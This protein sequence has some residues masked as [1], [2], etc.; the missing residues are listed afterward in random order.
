MP[1]SDYNSATA[2][3]IRAYF[4][5][6]RPRRRTVP[7]RRTRASTTI[8]RAYR[9]YRSRPTR[10]F[11]RKV[12]SAVLSRDPT[13]YRLFSLRPTGVSQSPFVFNVSDLK[14]NDFNSNLKYCRTSPK[15]KVMNLHCQLTFDVQD[16]PWNRIS[17]AFVRH[18]RSDPIVNADIQGAIAGALT[19]TDDKPFLPSSNNT[20]DNTY[21]N[22]IGANMT[23]ASA[24]ANPFI[25]NNLGWNP[26]VVQVLKTWNITLSPRNT[27]DSTATDNLLGQVYPPTRSI[28]WNHKFNEIW[29]YQNATSN[30]ADTTSEFPYN[31]KCYSFVLMSD[32]VTATSHPIASIACRL[33]FK[34]LD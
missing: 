14:Y 12:N 21:P 32:S 33:S 7:N 9:R 17:V 34:D 3:S 8:A 4:G 26:K 30:D 11:T 28:E 6:G 15:V 24:T 18:K 1:T 22:D 31:N 13:Q 23:G 20:A 10:S 29:K 5:I 19:N 16:A 25:L 2:R 27:N